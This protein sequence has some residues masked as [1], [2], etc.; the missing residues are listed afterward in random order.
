MAVKLP[1]V[2][3][4]VVAFAATTTLAVE[5]WDAAG[6]RVAIRVYEECSKSD[7]FSPCLKKKALAFFNRLSR[8]D[9]LALSDDL[10]IIKSEDA[11]VNE[12]A[13]NDEEIENSLPKDI[14]AK[15]AAL[16]TLLYNK[17][18]SFIGSRTLRFTMPKVSINDLGLQEGM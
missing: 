14:N 10:V 9:T 18:G 6:V 17:I 15:D 13:V 5:S 7:G 11:A 16:D 8:M 1:F 3:C 4:C 2:F 12:S